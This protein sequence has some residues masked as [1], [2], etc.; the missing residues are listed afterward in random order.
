MHL[1]LFHEREYVKSFICFP[2]TKVVLNCVPIS[3]TDHG[4]VTFHIA[5]AVYNTYAIFYNVINSNDKE[6][7]LIELYGSVLQANP[8]LEGGEAGLGEGE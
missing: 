6:I 5:E 1:I 2:R 3:S 7:Q 8:H 4:V